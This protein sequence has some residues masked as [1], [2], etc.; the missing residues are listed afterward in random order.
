MTSGR[1]D[2]RGPSA[3][4]GESDLLTSEDIFGDMLD[5]GGDRSAAPA[6]AP[7]KAPAAAARKSP[8]KVKLGVTGPGGGMAAAPPASRKATPL[9][10][11]GTGAALPDDVAARPRPTTGRAWTRWSR[12]C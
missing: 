12:T 1:D 5:A 6:P 2:D 3:P 8:I 9:T 10:T 7:A 4:P 11:P